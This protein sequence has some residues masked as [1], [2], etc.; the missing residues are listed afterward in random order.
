MVQFDL[1]GARIDFEK[2][3]PCIDDIA[4]FWRRDHS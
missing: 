2:K 4:V 3:V 1:L